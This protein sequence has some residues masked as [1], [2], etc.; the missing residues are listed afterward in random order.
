MSFKQI[1]GKFSSLYPVIAY[2]DRNRLFYLNDSGGSAL[3][4]GVV[5]EPLAGGD[6]TIAQRLG[7]LLNQD[8]P[9]NSVL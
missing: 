5:S 7:V 8:L 6:E 4:A 3:G 2:N 9:E 1:T